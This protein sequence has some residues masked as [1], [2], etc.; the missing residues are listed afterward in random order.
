MQLAEFKSRE[1]LG[2]CFTFLLSYV[3]SHIISRD[4]NGWMVRYSSVPVCWQSQGVEENIEN[5]GAAGFLREDRAINHKTYKNPM[6][7]NLKME[8]VF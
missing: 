8:S 2:A 4:H 1:N 6:P 5:R 3:A 7:Q